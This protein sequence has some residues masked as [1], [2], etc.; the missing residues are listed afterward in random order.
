MSRRHPSSDLLK[1]SRTAVA[2][3]RPAGASAPPA[4]A[5]LPRLGVLAR[6]RPIGPVLLILVAVLC[7][8]FLQS[9]LPDYT[10]FSNDGPLGRL[11]SQCQRLPQRF[12]GAWQDLNSIGYSQ[13]A[14]WPNITS[15]L[16]L[17]LGPVGFSKFYAPI[18]LLILGLSAWCYFRQLGL[19]P[20]ACVL[21]ALASSLNSGFFSAACWGMAAH[22][23]S[24]AMS[25]L[26]LAAIVHR[27]PHSRWLQAAVA[28]L[29]VGIS[30]AEGA[31]LGANFSLFV[32]AFALYQSLLG[33]GSTYKRLAGG[34]SQV[35]L[36]AGVAGLVAAQAVSVLVGTALHGV[37]RTETG[38]Q[39][40]QSRWDWATQWSLP[41]REAL[42]LI[43][44]GLF[45]YRMDAA[46]GG[47]YWG[48]VGRE[49]AWDRY[50]EKGGQGEAPAGFL[51]FSGGG[52]YAGV[53]V[54]LVAVWTACQSLRGHS[55]VFQ[56]QTR[57]HIYFWIAVSIGSLLLAFG[58]HAPFYWIFYQLP[59]SSS[60]R[61][62]AKFIHVVN[63]ALVVLFA[64]GIHGLS[65]LYLRRSAT[66]S[67]RRS[68]GG[69]WS[70][71][72]TFERRWFVGCSV[73]VAISLIAALAYA[74]WAKG[75]EG[76]LQGV[77]FD[78]NLARQIASFS[79]HEVSWYLVFLSLAVVLVLAISTGQFSGKACPWGATLLGLLLVVDLG[80]ADHPW[81]VYWN[82]EQKYAS[83]PIID[84]LRQSSYE[85]RAASLP[86]WLPHQFPLPQNL[87]TQEGHWDEA[88]QS[89]W[90]QQLFPYYDIQALDLVQMRAMPRD[91]AKFEEALQFRGTQT[92]LPFIAR[93]WELTNTRYLLG[94]AGLLP[95]LN[96]ALDPLQHRFTIVSR[97]DFF[98]KPGIV[99][100]TAFQEIT[101]LPSREGPFALFEFSGALPRASLYSNWEVVTNDDDTL[102][103]MTNA[104][105]NPTRTVIVSKPLAISPNLATQNVGSV[106][107]ASY[108]P[109]LIALQAIAPAPSV[110]LLND[111]F[112]PDWKV[113][114][115]GKLATLLRCNFIMRGVVVPAGEHQIQFQFTPRLG[116]L[117]LSVAAIA[118]GLFMT[119]RLLTGRRRGFTEQLPGKS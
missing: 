88:Y 95:L 71:A 72:T 56:L 25:F 11:M 115:D 113:S 104:D 90:L 9:F 38:I 29:A 4:T 92:T 33:G 43:V 39:N 3:F 62:P 20:L 24:V 41:K 28:G 68:L 66:D 47:N 76:Y 50:F 54:V 67:S 73:A 102:K 81:I 64:Y 59:Y 79:F 42:T 37:P 97:F 36:I 17:L 48:A 35:L 109:K 12:S 69:W 70:K 15:L 117:Y 75:L 7:V 8:S 93:R 89:E 27:S 60:I 49:P 118:A 86:A 31:D 61:N 74:C 10:L 103:L 107:F 34:A 105:F 119:G 16:L 45:G 23:L 114:I 6:L 13:G 106:T 112:D 94:C 55:S 116:P 44:P 1:Q 85:H 99:H 83:D 80:R 101:S 30:V 82:Y 32:A 14:A 108:S 53:L 84:K 40:E 110:L 52:N 26:A 78:E 65:G 46:G 96:Q 111:H 77:G 63:W 58:R 51:R 100:P 21:G 98:P 87:L 18:G 22:P 19:T 91:L 2:S 5:L 57:R